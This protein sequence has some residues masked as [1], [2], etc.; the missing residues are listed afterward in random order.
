MHST[1]VRTDVYE[2][3]QAINAEKG[4]TFTSF[5]LKKKNYMLR[6]ISLH[7]TQLAA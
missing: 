4:K 6:F 3:A 7:N 1:W 2:L 5:D